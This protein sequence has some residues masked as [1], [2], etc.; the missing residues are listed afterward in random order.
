LDILK[1]I[2][3]LSKAN[4]DPQPDVVFGRY[5]DAYKDKSK[6]EAWDAAMK[7]FNLENYTTYF[8]KFFYYL[9]DE[10]LGN[11]TFSTTEGVTYFEIFQGSKLLVGTADRNIIRVESKIAKADKINIGLLRRLLELN[12]T[13]KYSRYALDDNEWITMIFDAKSKD[14][15]PY[16]LYYGLKELALNSD[17][18]DDILESEFKSLSGINKT[19]IKDL[20]EAEKKIKFDYLQRSIADVFNIKELI[21]LNLDNFPGSISYLYLDVIYRLDYLLKPEGFV[22]EQFEKLH[23]AYYAQNG[24]APGHKNLTLYNGLQEIQKRSYDELSAEMYQVTSTFGIT[25]PSGHERLVEFIQK[26][27]QNLQ[28]YEVHGHDQIVQ[29]ICNYIVGYCLFNYSL[30]TPDKSFLHLYYMV[31]EYAFFK[32]LGFTYNLVS[33]VKLHK[34]RIIS[35]IK[36]VAKIHKDEFGEIIPD[37]SSLSFDSVMSFSKS[38]LLMLSNLKLSPSKNM[39][40]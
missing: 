29:S 3:G 19:H 14:T 10:D 8:E 16:K 25:Q 18:Q 28:Y 40:G 6:Y 7:E 5:T 1:K 4:N 38:Y 33:D 24:E 9:S 23:R 12:F 26:E 34:S 30:P 36:R 31:T 37:L 13:L 32:E 22:M 2:F 11:V 15:N 35:E 17:K 27:I 39:N 20:S 21:K